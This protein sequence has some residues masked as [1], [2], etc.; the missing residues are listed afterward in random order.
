M[1]WH[2]HSQYQR[3]DGAFGGYIVRQASDFDHHSNLYDEDKTG[4]IIFVQEYHHA[5]SNY[6]LLTMLQKAFS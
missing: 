1:F 4:H 2:S 3:G 6:V 5:V